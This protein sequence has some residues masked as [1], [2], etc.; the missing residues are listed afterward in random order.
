M[1]LDL[2]YSC[3]N[4]LKTNCFKKNKQEKERE[5]RELTC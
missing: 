3:I 2:N 5:E 1:P 4:L